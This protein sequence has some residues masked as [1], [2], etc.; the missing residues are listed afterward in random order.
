M[1]LTKQKKEAIISQVSELI[2]KSK[3]TIAA[4]YAGTSV[5]SLENL[6]KQAKQDGTTV[7]VV[8]NRLVVKALENN[9]KFK[10]IDLSVFKGML[11]YAFNENDELGSAQTLANFAKT[12]PNLE[13]IAGLSEKG[14][15]IDS[16][17]VLELAKLPSKNQL[18]S[19]L[20]GTLLE[21]LN[22]FVAV[23]NANLT[24][25]IYVLKARE[26]KIN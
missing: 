10:K 13:F 26:T 5:K 12:N 4:R 2:N 18:R 15:L 8:K 25:F 7:K 17:G 20:V 19:I 16:Q 1:A 24:S 9:P 3:L 23:L 6:R 14:E 22:G 21:P 11:I